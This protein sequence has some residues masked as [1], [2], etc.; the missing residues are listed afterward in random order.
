MGQKPGE[1]CD[2]CDHWQ[3]VGRAVAGYCHFNS[4]QKAGTAEVQASFPLTM[5]TD[6]C[7]EWLEIPKP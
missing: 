5:R 3:S 4:P 7:K 6:W 2:T 1:Q